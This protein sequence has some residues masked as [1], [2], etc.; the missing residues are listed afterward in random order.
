MFRMFASTLWR[1]TRRYWRRLKLKHFSLLCTSWMKRC[2]LW[3]KCK[4][5]YPESSK[6]I[7]YWPPKIVKR[8]EALTLDAGSLDCPS[9]LML[10]S[11]KLK[12]ADRDG[13]SSAPLS[14]RWYCSN[15]YCPLSDVFLSKFVRA[16]EYNGLWTM[17]RLWSIEPRLQ[18]G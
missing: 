17:T 10:N 15:L 11:N 12:T 8:R 18:Q 14:H 3:R 7:S 4:Y 6:I 13:K 1:L 16:G 5:V 9:K 2:F